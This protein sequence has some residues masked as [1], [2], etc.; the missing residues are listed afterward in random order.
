MFAYIHADGKG[1]RDAMYF[2]AAKS[3]DAINKQALIHI[4]D[5]A[6][7]RSILPPGVNSIPAE[8][9]AVFIA[10]KTHDVTKAIDAW[11]NYEKVINK[12]HTACHKIDPI[13]FVE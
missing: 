4:R 10:I 7:D 8:L 5:M 6:N 2:T 12:R 9:A 13:K 3:R 11:N 1:G